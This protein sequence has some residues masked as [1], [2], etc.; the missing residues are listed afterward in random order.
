MTSPYSE[1]YPN[2]FFFFPK[3]RGKGVGGIVVGGD[4]LD[5]GCKV[6]LYVQDLTLPNTHG[7]AIGRQTAAWSKRAAYQW[8]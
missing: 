4:F 8:L 3:D 6:L 1:T 2:F 5:A 7:K